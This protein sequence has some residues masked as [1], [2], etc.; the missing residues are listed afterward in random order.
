MGVRRRSRLRGRS[1]REHAVAELFGAEHVHADAVH[2]HQRTVHPPQLD[3]RP[4]QR[5]RRRQRRGRRV[6]RQVPHVHN[7]RIRLSERQ[8]HRHVV[9]LRQGERLR[10]L[11]GRA[12][13][14][15]Q[16]RR[17]GRRLSARHVPVRQQPHSVHRRRPRLQQGVGLFR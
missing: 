14:Y 12:Q 2:V 4:R 6:Q 11:V 13:L 17:Q 7:Q 16:G 10:R 5:L 9:P 1:R 8:V 3:V 15:G